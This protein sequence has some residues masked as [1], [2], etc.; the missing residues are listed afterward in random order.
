M[1]HAKRVEK[2]SVSLPEPLV[3]WLRA[4]GGESGLSTTLTKIV[5]EAREEDERRQAL[6]KL[7]RYLGP[8]AKPTDAELTAIDEELGI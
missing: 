2:L 4:R 5:R 7:L 8:I 3:K 1:G 6:G